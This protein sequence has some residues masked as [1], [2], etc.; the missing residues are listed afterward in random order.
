MKLSARIIVTFFMIISSMMGCVGTKPEAGAVT[1]K[2]RPTHYIQTEAMRLDG[3]IKAGDRILFVGDEITQ[4]DYYTRALS[5]ALI[6]LYPDYQLTFYN[7][8]KEGASCVQTEETIDQLLLLVRPTVVFVCLGQNDSQQYVPLTAHDPKLDQIVK[9][10]ESSLR[11][12]ISRVS[13]TQSLRRIIVLSAPGHAIL[14][15]EQGRP[16]GF[17]RTLR[18]LAL[19]SQRAAKAE[20]VGFVDLFEPMHIAHQANMQQGGKPLII[21]RNLP[22]E[23]AHTLMASAILWGMGVKD[24]QLSDLGWAPLPQIRMGSIRQALGLRLKVPPAEQSRLSRAIYESLRKPSEKFFILWRISAP[25]SRKKQRPASVRAP[26]ALEKMIQSDW[27]HIHSLAQ[28]YRQFK[29]KPKAKPR[30]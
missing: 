6:A 24:D 15:D 10:Y 5:S 11:R 12:L 8:G 7:G 20:H 16:T 18:A 13:S 3:L 14:A 28:S 23:S 9:D 22:N 17:N 30:H 27:Q 4:Q 29:K 2:P 21:G 26:K 1:Y 25:L 19:A